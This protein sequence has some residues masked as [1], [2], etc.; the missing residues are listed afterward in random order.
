MEHQFSFQF[1]NQKETLTVEEILSWDPEKR[2]AEYKKLVGQAPLSNM[3]PEQIGK[4][5]F[6]PEKER[7]RIL[8]LNREEDR[9]DARSH[10]PGHTHSSTEE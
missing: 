2:N 7:E 5:I 10:Y 3:T 1:E 4:G 8:I 9:E 6:D